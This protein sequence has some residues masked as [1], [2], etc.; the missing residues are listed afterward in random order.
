MWIAVFSLIIFCVCSFRMCCSSIAHWFTYRI[1]FLDY[2]CKLHCIWDVTLLLVSSRQ[3]FT[4]QLKAVKGICFQFNAYISVFVVFLLLFCLYLSFALTL[5][6]CLAISVPV[7]RVE[8][9]RENIVHVD[10]SG[11]IKSHGAI[12][13]LRIRNT[14][15]N[16]KGGSA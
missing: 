5:F 15:C 8:A 2:C 13:V 3:N 12:G 11:E 16:K 14:N 9:S 1:F 7:C 10:I 6:I 4:L